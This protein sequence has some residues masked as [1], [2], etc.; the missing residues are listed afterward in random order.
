M[1]LFKAYLDTNILIDYCWLAYFAEERTRKSKSYTLVNKG[2]MGEYEIFISFYTLLEISQHFTDYY[3]QQ[4]AIKDGYSFRE[5]PKVRRNY[6]LT[7]DETETISE[8]VENL[9]TNEFLNYIDIGETVNGHFFRIIMRY[10][11]EYVDFLDALHLRTAIDVG[12][13]YFVT[14]DGELRKRAQELINNKVITEPIKIASVSGF[15]KV[16]KLQRKGSQ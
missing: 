2:A 11:Q 13:D 16:L 3:L 14:K 12:C 15:L 9:R 7:K 6:T 8:L 5:F 1:K 10:V 4:K